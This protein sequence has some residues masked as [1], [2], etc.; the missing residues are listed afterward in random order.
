[1]KPNIPDFPLS[2]DRHLNGS[3]HLARE[4][5]CKFFAL[6]RIPAYAGRMYFSI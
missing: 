3:R 6:A 4:K 5:R 1:M 2:K